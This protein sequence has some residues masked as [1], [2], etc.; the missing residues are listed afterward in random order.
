VINRSLGLFEEGNTSEALI[1]LFLKLG[2]AYTQIKAW[3]DAIASLE[4]GLSIA[5][6][7]EDERIGNELKAIAKQAMGK[8][9]LEKYESLPERNDELVRKALFCTDAAF[10][11]QKSKGVTLALFLDLAQEYYL[12]GDSEKAHALLKRYLDESVRL[13]ASYCLREGCNHGEMSCL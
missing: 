13:G 10:H 8:V 6:S 12:L 9:Y 4:K 1:W 11:L 5:E 3:D 2:Q 7:I